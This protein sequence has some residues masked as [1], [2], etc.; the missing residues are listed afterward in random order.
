MLSVS[1]GSAGNVRGGDIGMVGCMK[2]CTVGVRLGL[3]FSRFSASSRIV[4]HVPMGSTGSGVGSVTAVV[5][6]WCHSGLLSLLLCASG[7]S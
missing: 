3:G 2:S 7:L 4:L 1:N 5:S 6:P